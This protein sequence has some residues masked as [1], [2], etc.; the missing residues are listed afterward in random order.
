[1]YS[2]LY[3]LYFYDV[4]GS[5][6]LVNNRGGIGYST[7]GGNYHGGRKMMKELIVRGYSTDK[8]GVTFYLVPPEDDGR[9]YNI[10]LEWPYLKKIKFL[11]EEENILGR[12]NENSG[13]KLQLDEQGLKDMN[14]GLKAALEIINE[15]DLE[16]PLY[17]T[18]PYHYIDINDGHKKVKFPNGSILCFTCKGKHNEEMLS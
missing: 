11:D 9:Y 6:F 1:M 17:P 15:E 14:K 12:L 5:N 8:D 16:S 13:I 7:C 3:S 10:K 18:K 2:R 4:N